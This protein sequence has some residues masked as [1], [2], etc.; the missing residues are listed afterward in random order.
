MTIVNY[1]KTT[2]LL[3]DR[4]EAIVNLTAKKIP[5]TKNSRLR[6]LPSRAGSEPLRFLCSAHIQHLGSI[7]NPS[8]Q[9][10]QLASSHTIPQ[11]SQTTAHACTPAGRLPFFCFFSVRLHAPSSIDRN[12]SELAPALAQQLAMGIG[13][14]SSI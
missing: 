2:N 9:S 4:K 13:R 5:E 10:L 3:F 6:L 12:S 1:K 11:A 7:T 8:I 14:Q